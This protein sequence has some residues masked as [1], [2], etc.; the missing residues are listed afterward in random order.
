[1]KVVFLDI[2][3]VLQPYDSSNSFVLLDKKQINAISKKYNVDYSKYS[4]SEV[5]SVYYDWNEQAIA[6]LK[7]ILDSTNSKIIISSDWKSMEYPY[8][9]RD[10]LKLYDLDSYWVADNVILGE[11]KDF[12]MRRMLEIEDS[13]NRYSIDNYVVLDDMRELSEYFPMN[14]VITYDYISIDNMNNC[15]KIL[16]RGN[17]KIYKN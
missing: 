7:Y 1:M 4:I 8:K 9:M 17:K 3:G 6:R 13:L 12:H 14:S 11:V 10:L 5:S 16:S 15:I 2:D